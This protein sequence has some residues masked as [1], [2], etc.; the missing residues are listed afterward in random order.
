MALGFPKCAIGSFPN[1]QDAQSAVQRLKDAN[2]PVN[3]ISVIAQ[4][5]D[6]NDA[7]VNSEKQFIRRKTI[8]G[9]M[10]V[11]LTVGVFG[12][13]LGLFLGVGTLA[14]PIMNGAT[15][16]GSTA[17][18][19]SV[20]GGFYG[21]VAG[22]IIGAALGNGIARRQARAFRDRLAQGSYVVIVEGSADAIRQVE[23]VLNEQGVA[24]WNI[25][26]TV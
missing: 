24:G 17:I 22:G 26:N 20:T 15:S 16:G 18:A 1:H 19:A 8:A 10:K 13:I 5:A 14:L 9:L 23:S 12:G 3:K 2:V 11:G 4:D 21:V 25:Y 6:Q 7:I